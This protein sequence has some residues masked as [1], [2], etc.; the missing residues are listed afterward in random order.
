MSVSENELTVP[1]SLPRDAAAPFN[2][3]HADIILRSAD[4]VDF[5]AH[6]LLLSMTS[7]IFQAMFSLPQPDPSS[8]TPSADITKDGLPVLLFPEDERSIRMMLACCYPRGLYP[9]PVVNSFEDIKRAL[10][11]ASKYEI[12]GVERAVVR[13]LHAGKDMKIKEAVRVYIVAWTMRL[14]NVVVA[15]ARHTLRIPFNIRA[16]GEFDEL[17]DL[18]ASALLKLVNYR[19]ACVNALRDCCTDLTWMA[20]S[21]FISVPAKCREAACISDPVQV[22]PAS[23]QNQPL[24]IR[25]W[26]AEY[27]RGV[28]LTV[29]D[30]P[31]VQA[32]TTR[33]AIASAVERAS[34]CSKCRI[35]G[36][37]S[38]AIILAN[39]R[40]S[41]ECGKR[42][43]R[44]ELSTPF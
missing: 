20:Q 25:G 6:K 23:G 5:R 22:L 24:F 36:T 19:A 8:P 16:I 32:F 31:N 13:R 39:R 4:G 33:T 29:A 10:H 7:P 18:P 43:E 28:C 9:E 26:W 30:A 27:F 12:P 37:V 21:E 14:R 42:L 44:V 3:D 15:A 11:L 38:A 40:L 1:H 41:E 17:D 2:A 35:N 34:S